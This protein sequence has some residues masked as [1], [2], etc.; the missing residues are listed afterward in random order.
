[1]RRTGTRTRPTVRCFPI[2]KRLT[3]PVVFHSLLQALLGGAQFAN[4]E[5]GPIF[6]TV[7]YYGW[8]AAVS[9]LL[10]N[11][12]IALFGSAYAESAEDSVPTFMVRGTI[13][14]RFSQSPSSP[15]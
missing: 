11:I 12:L 15:F 5:K 13:D 1:M 10:L 14:F 9:I 6:G 4:F 8:T 3:Y 7:I 2:V